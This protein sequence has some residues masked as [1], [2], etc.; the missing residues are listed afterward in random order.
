MKSEPDHPITSVRNADTDSDLDKATCDLTK[1]GSRR[2]LPNLGASELR[3]QRLRIPSETASVILLFCFRP[4]PA[5]SAEIA[6]KLQVS[7]FPEVIITL[8]Q[9]KDMRS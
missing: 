9:K 3:D 4:V 6:E 1:H 2:S 8:S 5:N 7:E